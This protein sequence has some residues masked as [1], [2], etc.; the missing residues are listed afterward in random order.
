MTDKSI[1]SL[2][3][4]INA[5]LAMM[6]NKGAPNITRTEITIK[7]LNLLPSTP[8][9]SFALDKEATMYNARQSQK[10]RME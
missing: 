4:P 10:T 3:K 9:H 1:S 6:T 8:K 5:L 7:E 2:L